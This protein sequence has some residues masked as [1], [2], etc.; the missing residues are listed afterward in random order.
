[1]AS[2]Q[3]PLP[4]WI[5][6]TTKLISGYAA[7]FDLLD[8]SGDVIKR[9]AF[10]KSLLKL[11][12]LPLLNSHDPR[13]SLGE[14]LTAFENEI[15]LFIIAAVATN[16]PRIK[17]GTG[18]SFAYRVVDGCKIDQTRRLKRL[19]LIEISLT[20]NPMVPLCRIDWIGKAEDLAYVCNVARS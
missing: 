1:M 17:V 8:Q 12:S 3:A 2:F 20:K 18:L 16:W 15:G 7:I 6:P 19:E 14:V 5:S 10:G 11:K 4:K 9:G 13:E